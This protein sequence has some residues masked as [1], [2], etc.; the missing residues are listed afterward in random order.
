MNATQPTGRILASAPRLVIDANNYLGETPVWS[1]EENALYWI[2]VENPPTLSRWD[3]VSGARRDWPMRER[4]GGFVLK[5]NGG[6]VLVL[7][8]G[9]FD[10][11]FDSGALILR[12]KSPLPPHISLHECQ[13]DRDGRLWVGA[14]NHRLRETPEPPGGGMLFRLD[15]DELVP[16]VSGISCANGLAFSPAGD[17]LYLTDSPLRRVE[18]WAL[19]R[20]N[21]K[22]S[23]RREFFTVGRGEGFVDGATV[24]SAGCYW[25]TLVYGSAIRCYR[26]DGTLAARVPLPF[27]NP[28]KVAFGGPEMRTLFITTCKLTPRSGEPDPAA[29]LLGGVFALDLDVAGIPDTL[30]AG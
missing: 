5:E 20:R 15:A 27:G 21:G 14:I 13:C 2:N 11:D 29:A 22:L 23:D 1:R 19:D 10:F 8:S 18:S 12:A 4:I 6:A 25:A 3:F 17:R 9:V 28:T 30:F 7:A 26:A 24:D 16:E